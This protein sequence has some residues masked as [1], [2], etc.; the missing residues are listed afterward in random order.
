MR[1]TKPLAALA[2]GLAL[3][4]PAS[5]EYRDTTVPMRTQEIDL[6]SYLGKWYEVARY[7]NSFERGC[8]APTATYSLNEDGSIEVLNACT[9][10]KSRAAK[11]VKVGPGKLEVDF[12]SWLPGIAKGDYWVLYVDPGYTL[13][14]VGEPT[15]RYGWVLSRSPQI[16]QS[17]LDQAQ[18]VLMQNGYD[19]SGLMLIAQ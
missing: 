4:A 2:A 18:A 16:R 11:A 13:A 17:Q 1:L 10:G 19:L 9:N 14:V 12:V 8:Q 15:G 6:Q 7:P 3:T 5:A